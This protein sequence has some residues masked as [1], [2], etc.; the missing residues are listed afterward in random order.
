MNNIPTVR[1]SQ[2][3]HNI[4]Q[5]LNSRIRQFVNDLPEQND[6]ICIL[7]GGSYG[8]DEG[9]VYITQEGI[10]NLFGTVD[11]FVITRPMNSRKL[12]HIQDILRPIEIELSATHKIDISFALPVPENKISNLRDSLLWNE[13]H[14][15]SKLVWGE[16]SFLKKGTW[17]E[18]GEIL[19]DEAMRLFVN[20]MMCFFLALE[21]FHTRKGKY[22]TNDL[23]FIARNFNRMALGTCDALLLL[24]SKYCYKATERALAINTHF[25][26]L[27]D[28][29]TDALEFKFAPRTPSEFQLTLQYNLLLEWIPK[30]IMRINQFFYPD[31]SNHEINNLFYDFRTSK[32]LPVTLIPEKIKNLWYNLT[33]CEL[34]PLNFIFRHPREKIYLKI[35]KMV[36]DKIPLEAYI[37]RDTRDYQS[38]KKDWNRFK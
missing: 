13:L 11:Y 32:E 34:W 29:Y 23:D 20:R 17:R 37:T 5:S 4:I 3:C 27:F 7:L 6:I 2:V 1:K 35:L 12:Q 38:L 22:N 28:V 25:H 16:D 14:A 31:I 30:Q 19:S 9:G 24:K 36:L 26:D 10:E 21:R 8:R 15:Q 18:P 33:A